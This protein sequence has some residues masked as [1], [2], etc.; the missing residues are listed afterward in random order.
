[1]LCVL[2]CRTV[3]FVPF[4]PRGAVLTS[5]ADILV[6]ELFARDAKIPPKYVDKYIEVLAYAVS[7]VDPCDVTSEPN[8]TETRD[9]DKSDVAGTVRALKT[10]RRLCHQLPG[11]IPSSAAEFEKQIE[12][13][14]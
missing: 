6:K 9:I 2:C 12:Y 5:L 11:D 1:M 8:T 10:A 13:A 3:P 14:A 7:A 4:V